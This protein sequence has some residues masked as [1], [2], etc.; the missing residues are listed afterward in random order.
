MC[1][2]LDLIPRCIFLNSLFFPLI[3]CI[4]CIQSDYKY[5]IIREGNI[6]SQFYSNSFVLS[7]TTLMHI[8][9]TKQSIPSSQQTQLLMEM[10]DHIFQPVMHPLQVSL[11]V[12]QSTRTI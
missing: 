4:W 1:F 7:S 2:V 5:E 10:D 6:L 11:E 9:D 3:H 8:R 12:G